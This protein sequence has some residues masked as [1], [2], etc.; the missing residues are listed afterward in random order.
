M[1]SELRK[2]FNENAP[3]ENERGNLVMRGFRPGTRYEYDEKLTKAVG[4]AQYDTHQDAEYFGVWVSIK[5]LATF[6]YCEGDITLV[7][8]PSKEHLG[9]ELEDAERVY[10]SPPPAFVTIDNDGT[11]TEYYDKRPSIEG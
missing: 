1:L 2:L 4:W 6:T 7:I 11:R 9:A 3:Y 5:E 10:G 8:C